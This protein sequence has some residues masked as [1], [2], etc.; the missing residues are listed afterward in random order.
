MYQEVQ[1]DELINGEN[2][3]VKRKKR[4][5][6]MNIKNFHGLF[7]G[8]DF[9]GFVW[10]KIY[11]EFNEPIDSIELDSQLNTFYRYVS[12]EEFYAKLK[13]KYDHKCLNIIL[14][15]LIDESFEW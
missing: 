6:N 8:S 11:N 2:Y 4:R 1:E 15:R 14:K 5:N 13:E 9:E 3:Y 7:N 10:F 12:K